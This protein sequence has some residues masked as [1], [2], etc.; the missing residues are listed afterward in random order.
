MKKKG[1]VETGEIQGEYDVSKARPNHYA[2]R[3]KVYG[4]NIVVIEPDL[5]EIFPSSDAVNDALRMFARVSAKVT[6]AKATKQAHP[7]AS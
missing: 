6:K 3:I 1:T 7:K 4:S 2:E 5:Y